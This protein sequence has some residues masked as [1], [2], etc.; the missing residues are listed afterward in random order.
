MLKRHEIEILLKAGHGKAEVAR[1]SGASLRSVKRIAQEGPVVHIDDAAERAQRQV[2]RPST[3][4][5]FR[6]LAVEILEQAPELPSLEILRR[7]RESGYRGGKTALYA[8]V[9]SLRPK[10]VKPLVRFE[11]LAGEFSQHDFGKVEIE[12]VDG[13]NRRIH[14]FASRLKYSRCMCVSLVR[15]EAVESLV[16][17]LAE[18]LASWGGAPL[19]CVF[20]RP[21]TIALRWGKN[22]EVTEWNPVFAYATLEMGI[23]VELCLPYRAEQKGSVENLNPIDNV[24]WFAN[25]VGTAKSSGEICGSFTAKSPSRTCWTYLLLSK[26]QMECSMEIYKP[27]LSSPGCRDCCTD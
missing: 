6:K 25:L 17:T 3:V 23:G 22:G 13:S 21:K 5:S 9:A 14:F 8:L 2:G 7:V 16:R 20:D 4:A 24:A 11:G 26:A 1:L 27:Q 10:P 15:D 12:F 19:Q 18:H